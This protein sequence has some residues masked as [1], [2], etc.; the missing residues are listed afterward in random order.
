MMLSV[1]SRIQER[2]VVRRK[3]QQIAD[4]QKNLEMERKRIVDGKALSDLKQKYIE[5]TML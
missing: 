1:S 4:E 3:E 2:I 5:S